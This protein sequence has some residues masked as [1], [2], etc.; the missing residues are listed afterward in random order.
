MNQLFVPLIWAIPIV[1]VLAVLVLAIRTIKRKAVL[2]RANSSMMK[3]PFSPQ[4]EAKAKAIIRGAD[5]PVALDF[6]LEHIGNM[7]DIYLSTERR[8]FDRLI[9]LVK[10]EAFQ[11]YEIEEDYLVFH[12]GGFY[13]I[14]TGEMEKDEALMIN[15]QAIDLSEVNEIGEGI[16]IRM[17]FIPKRKVRMSMLFSAPSQFQLREIVETAITPFK[18]RGFRIPQSRE[19]AI[20][21]F[22]SPDFLYEA[23]K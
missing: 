15:L 6:V 21:E 22:N 8:Y 20:A 16:A 14:L 10:R 17:I 19:A 2:S 1:I 23:A 7:P 3:I 11:E 5:F 9:K 18:G 13:E 4:T 12:H